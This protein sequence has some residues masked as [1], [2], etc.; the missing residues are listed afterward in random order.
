MDISIRSAQQLRSQLRKPILS[1]RSSLSCQQ[2]RHAST[3]I[4][5]KIIRMAVFLRSKRV[6]FYL[7]SKGEVSTLMLLERALNLGKE[8]FLPILHPVKHN[9]L[10]FGRYEKGDCLRANQFGILEPILYDVK[11]IPAWTLDLVFTPLVAFDYLGNRLGMGGGYY[12]RTFSFLK[13]RSKPKLIGLAY[14]FQQIPKVPFE[15]WDIP[16]NIIITENQ[17]LGN[18]HYQT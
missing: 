12:D 18:S 11:K 8:C 15:R 2:Q 10:L 14:D 17:V 13:Y 6:A 1:K 16:L 7:A 9:C 4:S 3:I 5:K